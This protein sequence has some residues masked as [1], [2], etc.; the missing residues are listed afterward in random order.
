MQ[1]MSTKRVFVCCLIQKQMQRPII[2]LQRNVSIHEL[3]CYKNWC[4]YRMIAF[5]L[6]V[7][8]EVWYGFKDSLFIYCINQS[9]IYLT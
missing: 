9:Y 3:L 2:M 6:D 4:I 5:C 8:N 1:A 7:T